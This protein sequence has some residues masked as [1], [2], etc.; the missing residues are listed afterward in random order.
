MLGVRTLIQ[1]WIYIQCKEQIMKKYFVKKD[2]KFLNTVLEFDA[3]AYPAEKMAEEW[4]AHEQRKNPS[5][6]YELFSWDGWMNVEVVKKLEESGCFNKINW[7]WDKKYI[8]ERDD[9]E[10]WDIT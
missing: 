10:D 2:G 3:K 7:N 1:D 4:V 8:P 5:S 9:E 6:K